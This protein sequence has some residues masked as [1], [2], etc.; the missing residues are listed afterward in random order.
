MTTHDLWFLS[1]GALT[2]GDFVLGSV[3]LVALGV[4]VE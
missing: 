2:V 3:L 1:L 4:V